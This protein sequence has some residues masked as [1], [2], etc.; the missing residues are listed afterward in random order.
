MPAVT[1]NPP[2]RLVAGLGNPGRR[3]A[4]SRHNVGFRVAEQLAAD[5][6]AEFRSHSRVPSR[7][8]EWRT[9][10][11]MWI[12]I[13]P[14][15]FM[16]RSG[17]AVAA[18]L[19]F[20]KIATQSLL[21]VVDD[22]ELNPGELRLRGSGSAGGHN[23]L[24]SIIERLDSP[25]FARLRVGIGR[26]ANLQ[27]PLADWLLEPFEKSELLW[28]PTSIKSATCAVKA[29]A[30]E[31]LNVA[32]NRYNRKTVPDRPPPTHNEPPTP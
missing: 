30:L 22:V 5:H 12:A 14:T 25:Q 31:G 24:K 17:D 6:G 21:V 26:P 15:T 16:N 11:L 9:E 18:A 28:L 32:M 20:W 27:V 23:G 29:W 13:Q 19:D 7:V 10:G 1:S 3:Y 4:A 8:A 2:V